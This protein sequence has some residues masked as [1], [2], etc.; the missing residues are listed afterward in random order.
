M[1]QIGITK[2]EA[3]V[4]I[5]ILERNRYYNLIMGDTNLSSSSE[6]D[7]TK[8]INSLQAVTKVCVSHVKDDT[9]ETYLIENF[10]SELPRLMAVL[11]DVASKKEI[12]VEVDNF[13]DEVYHASLR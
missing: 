13:F 10:L 3:E 7:F 6:H 9:P 5:G 11:Y 8:F 2:Q 4:I 12:A 1:E